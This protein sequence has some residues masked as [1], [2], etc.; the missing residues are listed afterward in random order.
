MA[1][2]FLRENRPYIDKLAIQIFNTKTVLPEKFLETDY[3]ADQTA[4]IPEG[5]VF[6]SYV[7]RMGMEMGTTKIKDIEYFFQDRHFP[8]WMKYTNQGF[9]VSPTESFKNFEWARHYESEKDFLEAAGWSE[10]EKKFL[11]TILY[12]AVNHKEKKECV[13]L[14]PKKSKFTGSENWRCR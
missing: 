1:I 14:L 11:H 3:A 4:P 9:E 2:L 13:L 5:F 10:T 7:E 8:F 6:R 12:V